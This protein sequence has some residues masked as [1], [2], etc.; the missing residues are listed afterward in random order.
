VG[1]AGLTSEVGIELTDFSAS[2]LSTI[3]Q[4]GRKFEY[5]YVRKVPEPYEGGARL[6]G[7]A[8]HKGVDAWY[9][10]PDDGFRTTDLAPIICAQWEELLPPA[11]W[12]QV[13]YLRDLDEE[14]EA[15][16]ALILMKRPD[17][18]SVRA[19]VD[20]LRSDA[21][22]KYNEARGAMLEFCD[23]LPDVKWPKDEDPYK[24]YQK[25]AEW[26]V[27]MQRRWQKL[28]RPLVTE[29]GFVIE[30]FGFRVRGF[31]DQIRRD[32]GP[33]G[34]VLETV[35]DIKSGRQPMTPMEA[36]LQLWIYHKATEANPDWPTVNR[37]ALYLTRKDKYQQGRI[38]PLRHDRLA[39]RVFNDRARKI[40]MAQFAPEPGFWCKSCDFE[41]LCRQELSLWQ[42]DGLVAELMV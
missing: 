40:Q 19:T 38:D 14:C 11:V 16:A 27:N 31:I 21:A 22:K 1:I 24:A 2:R 30:L 41:D 39:S 29:G 8:V 23:L 37:I 25:A 10:L 20:F 3:G 18:K 42:G 17:L 5:A 9:A 36:F 28:P 32:P 12:A 34:E 35:V 26:G 13:K 33:N 15:V 4:C 6:L 7:S